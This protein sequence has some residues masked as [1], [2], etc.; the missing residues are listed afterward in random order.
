MAA[1]VEETRRLAA[2]DSVTGL[3]NRRAFLDA[4]GRGKRSRA[5]RHGLCACRS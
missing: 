1:L 5:E 3:L 2:V 4:M